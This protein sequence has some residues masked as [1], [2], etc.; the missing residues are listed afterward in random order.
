MRAAASTN[1]LEQLIGRLDAA[2]PTGLTGWART[3][4]SEAVELQA[5]WAVEEKVR[6]AETKADDLPRVR[7]VIEHRRFAKDAAGQQLAT[8]ESTGKE[9]VILELFENE[10]PNTVANFLD[11]VG[12]GFYDGTSFHLAIATVMAVGGDPNTKNA[13]PADDGMGGPGHVIPAEHQAPKARRLFRGSLAMLPNGPR[14]AGSQFFFTLSPR[15][16][17][18]GEVTVFGRVLKGQE[19]VDNI[20]RGRTTRNVGVFGR[21]IPGDL[22]VSAEILRKRAHA[23]PVKK[24]KK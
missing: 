16:D 13:D 7:L 4:R 12:R 8:I 15:R 21:I 9:E 11:L 2:F 3:L 19:A 18:H 20:T 6:L 10:A 1:R 5:Q 22:L 14:S 23:Y 24:E 17:M